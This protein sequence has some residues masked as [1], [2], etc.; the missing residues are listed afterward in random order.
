MNALPSMSRYGL[1]VLLISIFSGC[2]TTDYGCKG[3]PD[4]PSC[5]STTQAYQVTNSAITEVPPENNPSS[6]TTSSAAL[7]PPLQQP[8]PKIEDPTPIRT[9]SQVMRIW[10]APWEDTD[11]DLMVSN[12]VY[13]ELEPR[14]W[15]IGKAAPTASSSLIPLQVEQRP[16]EKRPT[17][18]AN[19]DDSPSSRLGK[20]L[21]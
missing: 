1:A 17:V 20:P 3:M 11:G 5:L 2:A 15:M 16:P 21:P 14:R 12:Y 19:D 8:V 7:A 6:E 9:P 18:D 10:I 4:E 13:T